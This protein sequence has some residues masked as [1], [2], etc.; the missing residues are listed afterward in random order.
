M[1][2]LKWDVSIKALLSELGKYRK[3]VRAEEDG[4]HHRNRRP[5]TTGLMN[6]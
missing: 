5:E 1:L 4:Q 6:V 2:S 3:I